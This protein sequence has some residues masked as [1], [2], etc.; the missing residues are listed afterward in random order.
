M[1]KHCLSLA[2]FLSCLAFSLAAAGAAPV[3]KWTDGQGN[4][5]FSDRPDELPGATRIELPSSSGA[6]AGPPPARGAAATDPAESAESD[7]PLQA[8]ADAQRQVREKN[9]EIAR[10][11]R[12]HN[13]G[14][15][16]M[17]RLGPDGERVFLSDEER[18]EVL[19]RS[20]DDVDRWC[21]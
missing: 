7:A 17:Y 11:T 5:H 16:R 10:E 3:Y 4:V 21:D 18:D 12:S 20:R 14:I 1:N 15:D 13:E 19:R 6:K 8:D 2:I 9:C